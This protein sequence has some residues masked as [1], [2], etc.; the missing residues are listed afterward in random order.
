[1]RVA[2]IAAVLVASL[3][4]ASAV[5]PTAAAQGYIPPCTTL[6]LVII[7]IAT[8]FANCAN[9]EVQQT[10]YGVGEGGWC[11]NPAQESAECAVAYVKGLAGIGPGCPP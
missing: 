1:M 2:A 6:C 11:T 5:A 7:V 3:L 9:A 10:V 8:M 4:V